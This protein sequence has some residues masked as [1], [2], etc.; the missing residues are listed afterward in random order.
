MHACI[1][2]EEIVCAALVRREDALLL[3]CTVPVP[4][5][6]QLGSTTLLPFLVP[7]SVPMIVVPV[8]CCPGIMILFGSC[9][10]SAISRTDAPVE[11]AGPSYVIGL[12]GRRLMVR[13]SS[14]AFAM[15]SLSDADSRYGFFVHSV[16]PSRVI[17]RDPREV[18]L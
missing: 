16:L 7:S 13:S 3:S 18:E 14:I 8:M 6:L 11:F 17:P 12:P 9:P 4:Y 2:D 1:D 10:L 15:A 5:T